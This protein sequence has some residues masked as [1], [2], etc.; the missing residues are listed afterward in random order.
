MKKENNLISTKDPSKQKTLL[1]SLLQVIFLVLIAITAF[2]YAKY[3]F[4]PRLTVFYSHMIG[5]T[6]GIM[7][8]GVT[9]YN[10]QK[11]QAKLL[12]EKIAETGSRLQAEERYRR[13]VET[14]IEGIW[15]INKDLQTTFVNQRIA[16]MLGFTPEEMSGKLVDSFMFEEDWERYT[17]LTDSRRQGAGGV[18]E[19]RFRRKDGTELWCIVSSSALFDGNG[20]F[21]GRFAMFTD[22]TERKRSDKTLQESEQEAKHLAKENQLIS[23]IGRI[24]SS[25]IDIEEVYERFAEKI[26]ETIP[27]DR[28]AINMVN[29]TEMIRITQ[30]YHGKGFEANNIGVARPLV[31]TAVGE[32]ARIKTSL[33]INGSNR[34]EMKRTFPGI[35]SL[36][37]GANT[38]IIVPLVS[39]DKVIG[40][41][42][43]H[44]DKVDAY[45]E[46]DLRLAERV[47]NQIA[48]TVANAQLYLEL[49]RSE[50]I[51]EKE[52]GRLQKALDEVH[53]LRGIVPICAYCKKVRDDTGY[54]NQVEQY[55]SAHTEAQ[56]SHGICPICFEKEMKEL[57]A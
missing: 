29:W 10:I 45:S 40:A 36:P 24:I 30:Y 19:R 22:I 57:K 3:I 23:E 38:T 49:K 15:I 4:F 46:N 41:L 18:V 16:D 32:A 11:K 1:I 17:L 44:S 34:E 6:F 51:L 28:I 54:W 20:I 42:S 13:I 27:F 37:V 56:F 35:T 33:L 9:A 8:I 14:S 50:G 52:R 47:G 26:K 12:T 2:E 39:Q 7:I 43:V 31:G 48:G 21:S 53:T 25:T 55:V 5:I